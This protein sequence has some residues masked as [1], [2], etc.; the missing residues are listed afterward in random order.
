MDIN[1]FT[2]RAQEAVLTAQRRAD[3]NGN[4]NVEP[5]HLLLT[6][7]QQQ[8]GV[9]PEIIAKI[10]GSVP[11]LIAETQDMVDSL[12][13]MSGATAQTNLSADLAKALNQAEKEAHRMHDE[14]TSTEHILLG[15]LKTS[16][17]DSLLARY[18]ITSDNVLCQLLNSGIT[19]QSQ[20]RSYLLQLNV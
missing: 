17:L 14:Y 9:V 4:P 2:T 5:A 11:A 15:L 1:R 18:G 8:Q 7:L 6:L 10:G 13:R 16:P 12:P 20:F 3:E 19:C